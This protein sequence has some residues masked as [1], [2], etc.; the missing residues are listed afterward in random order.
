MARTNHYLEDYQ[1][2]KLALYHNLLYEYFELLCSNQ[3]K[4][5]ICSDSFGISDIERSK[6]AFFLLSFLLLYVYDYSYEEAKQIVNKD[7]LMKHKITVFGIG[8][9]LAI[10]S[11]S[12]MIKLYSLQEVLLA[13]V[14]SDLDIETDILK[15]YQIGKSVTKKNHP[16]HFEYERILRLL[17]YINSN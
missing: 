15:I 10:P 1:K 12:G 14:Y 7:W 3:T 8:K 9:F 16:V 4:P 5:Q 17:N 13:I 2:N 11:T 6:S